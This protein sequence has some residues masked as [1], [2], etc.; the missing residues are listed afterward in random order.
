M[1][2]YHDFEDRVQDAREAPG[3][4]CSLLDDIVLAEAIKPETA[5]ER[6]LLRL[7]HRASTRVGRDLRERL[8]LQGKLKRVEAERDTALGRVPVDP[9]LDAL[10]V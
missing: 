9:R 7:L 2:D 10:F 3:A 6:A 5:R 4:L 8:I 1:S